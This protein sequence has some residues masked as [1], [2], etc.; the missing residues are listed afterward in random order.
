VDKTVLEN[1]VGTPGYLG[2]I[3]I[4]MGLVSSTQVESA[5]AE[6]SFVRENLKQSRTEDLG[7][8]IKVRTEKL[9]ELVNLVGEFVSLH[10]RI[11][12]HAEKSSDQDLRSM[13]EQM[14]GLVRQF[15]D[16]SISMHM[17][18]IGMLFSGFRR[19]VRDVSQELGK[20]VQLVLE[21]TETELDKTITDSL[22]D[23][24]LHLVRNSVDH[25]IE[26]PEVRKNT[27]KDPRGTLKLSA[28]YSGASVILEIQDDGKGID[29]EKI[30]QKA[31]EKG[32]VNPDQVLNKQDIFQLIF[33]PGF[34]RRS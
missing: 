3:L 19:L 30:R 34:S 23:P 21:G 31:L 32:L 8:T 26:T 11:G 5:L 9:E 1:A 28:Y 7:S 24:L 29:P 16:L 33:A 10:A 15:R 2:E 13:G 25:G 17:V 20:D 12:L 27:G 18:P 22:K 4:Q 6:Q 14:D